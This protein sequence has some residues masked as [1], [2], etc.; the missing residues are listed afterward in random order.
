MDTGPPAIA[1]PDSSGSS[2]APKAKRTKRTYRACIPCRS[3]S[4]LEATLGRIET[5]IAVD[6]EG[7][8]KPTLPYT[9]NRLVHQHICLSFGSILRAL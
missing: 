3:V 8:P 6:L 2:K 1:G 7:P 4:S 5:T 9:D